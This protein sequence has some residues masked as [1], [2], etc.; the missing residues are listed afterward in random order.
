MVV[1]I[2]DDL[3]RRLNS[4]PERYYHAKEMKRKTGSNKGF[5]DI[6]DDLNSFE[7][8][9]HIELD[10]VRKG[11]KII[12]GRP[13]KKFTGEYSRTKAGYQAWLF[14][15]HKGGFD[16]FLRLFKK[17][18]V[19]HLDSG[20]ENLT[21]SEIVNA[22]DTV[23]DNFLIIKKKRFSQ[24]SFPFVDLIQKME[25]FRDLIKK[26]MMRERKNESGQK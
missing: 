23:A 24:R 21:E 6:L 14:D 4:L 1:W 5:L 19:D 11:N 10:R 26:E 9:V 15:G 13:I 22:V 20:E 8:L 7:L 12:P 17:D 3:F 18:S 25:R 16:D 2:D